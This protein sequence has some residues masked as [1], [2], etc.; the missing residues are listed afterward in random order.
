M[1]PPSESYFLPATHFKQSDWFYCGPASARS[2]LTFHKSDSG[3]SFPL[4]TEELL[5]S[6]MLTT[7]QGTNSLNLA[8][9]LN[10][11]KD[12]YDFADSTYGAIT[13]GSINE[14]VSLVKSKLSDRTNVPIVLTN[15]DRLERYTYAEKNYRHYI[16]INGYHGPDKTMQIVDPNHKKDKRGKD[17]GGSYEEKIDNDGKGVGQAVLSVKGENPTLIY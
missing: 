5:A 6:L 1:M 4:P 2:V 9:G 11:Y 12:N 10:A 15:T 8:W 7:Q 16:V 17:L 14:L 3:S 13:P